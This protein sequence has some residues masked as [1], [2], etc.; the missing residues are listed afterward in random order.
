[1]QIHARVTFQ[2]KIHMMLRFLLLILLR[3]Y[4]YELCPAMIIKFLNTSFSPPEQVGWG[5]KQPS[6]VGGIAGKVLEHDKF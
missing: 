6:L 4:L 1:M 5:L 3:M 2:M